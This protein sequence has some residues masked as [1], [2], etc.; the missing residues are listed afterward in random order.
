MISARRSLIGIVTTSSVVAAVALLAGCGSSSSADTAVREAASATGPAAKGAKGAKG[1]YLD[2]RMEVTNKTTTSKKV[3]MGAGC[4][5]PSGMLPVTLP[6]GEVLAV[7]GWCGLTSADV[8]G[9]LKWDC[10]FLSDCKSVYFTAGNPKI[11]WPW[12]VVDGQSK[13]FGQGEGC[14][15]NTQG[16]HF[17]AYRGNDLSG[18]KD[19]RL[20]WVDQSDLASC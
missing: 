1:A 19:M 18:A 2:T 20:A 3:V 16:Q 6:P 8:T 9:I 12:M 13:N 17:E 7:T 4:I 14:V 15:F 11:G 5:D 10:G